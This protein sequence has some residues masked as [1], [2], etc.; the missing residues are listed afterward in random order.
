MLRIFP[1]WGVKSAILNLSHMFD[2]LGVKTIKWRQN[3]PLQVSCISTRGGKKASTEVRSN[4]WNEASSLII[5]AKSE[6]ISKFFTSS[7]HSSAKEILAADDFD[8]RLLLAKRSEKS[9]HLAN[10]Y[11]FPGGYVDLADF[12]AEWWTVFEAAGISRSQLMA[13][14]NHITGSRPPILTDNGLLMQHRACRAECLP[15]GI[16]LRITAIRETFEETGILLLSHPPSNETWQT[17][18]VSD[19]NLLTEVDRK[20]WQKKIHDDPSLFAAFCL[21]IGLCPDI[22]SLREW[23]NWLTPEAITP[24]RFDTMF[25]MCCLES[26]P[27]I[28]PDEN[29]VSKLEWSSPTQTLQ[30]HIEKKAVL[31]PP[32]VYELSRLRNFS[33]FERLKKFAL[34]REK[35]GVER[36]CPQVIHV[37][38]GVILALPGDE[39]YDQPPALSQQHPPM[40][41]E[42]REKTAKLNRMEIKASKMIAFTNVKASHGHEV[43]IAYPSLPPS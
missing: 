12:S 43:P 37:N 16:A 23:W 32:Q 25:Y 31:A 28:F 3:S 30:K 34:T 41:Q 11:V 5:A 40:L 15:P 19:E 27:A 36:W 29:E 17:G 7:D 20:C 8:Y 10:A 9:S 38:D 22:W 1:T 13:L 26:I 42:M 21:H 14:G 33:S 18:V 35:E 39:F 24:K 6:L 4:P 2:G